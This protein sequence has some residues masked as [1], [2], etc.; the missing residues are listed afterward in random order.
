MKLVLIVLSCAVTCALRAGVAVDVQTGVPHRICTNEMTLSWD[1]SWDWIPVNAQSATV[2]AKMQEGG[3]AFSNTV[4]RPATSVT[5]RV[6]ETPT[7]IVDAA[8]DV[9]LSFP[10]AGKLTASRTFTCE[11]RAASFAPHVRACSTNSPAWY[12]FE[13]PASFAYNVNWFPGA[14]NIITYIQWRNLDDPSV[15]L[16]GPPRECFGY[17]NK[18]LGFLPVPKNHLPRAKYLVSIHEA[19]ARLAQCE[20]S[21]VTGMM[22]IFK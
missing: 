3:V 6:F 12:R 19:S 17:L 10:L 8:Y 16:I 21:N 5:W 15:P 2:V 4:E 11:L 1:W 20:I 18:A 9:T 13:L 14:T 7:A 22:I